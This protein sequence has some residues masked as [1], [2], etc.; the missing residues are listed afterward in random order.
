VRA[1][2]W[3]SLAPTLIAAWFLAVGA[4]EPDTTV[5]A[6]AAPANVTAPDLDAPQFAIPTTSDR[7]G[8]VVAAVYIGE[9]GPLRFI[10]DTGANR[11][12][13]A[14]RTVRDLGLMP[15]GQAMVHGITGSAVMPTVEVAQL[16][17][18][19]LSFPGQRLAVLPDTVFAGADGILGID[20]VQH[21]RIDVDFAN[22][23]VSVRRSGARA[24]GDRV[25]VPA[26][27]SRGGLL[28]IR[29]KVGR[30][31]VKAIIDTGAERSLGN[32][33]LRKALLVREKQW[34]GGE[35]TKVV[36]ATAQV[37]EGYV[38][39]APTVALGGDANVDNLAVTFGDFHVFRIWSLLDEPALVIG[40]DALGTLP[41]FS[42]DYPRRQF[43]LTLG[44]AAPPLAGG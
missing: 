43:L 37:A 40:M 30:V 2:R 1:I 12:A 16:R 3:Q 10:L 34:F 27:L 19:E 42:V 14:E 9:R 26:R 25:V 6:D 7:V 36:G 23:Q 22:D 32:E 4:A 28:L 39:V 38:F 24:L 35:A 44:H 15:G 13:L 33:A 11:S 21:A 41:G 17:V 18:G 5:P 31:R 20:I 29:G 8:R